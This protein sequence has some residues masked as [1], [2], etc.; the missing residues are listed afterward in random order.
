MTTCDHMHYKAF[1]MSPPLKT[2][3]VQNKAN[4]C[5]IDRRTSIKGGLCAVKQPVR[6]RTEGGVWDWGVT[7]VR[8]DPTGSPSHLG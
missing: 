2:V 6:A 8:M 1:E 7:A 4:Y 3:M 5:Q